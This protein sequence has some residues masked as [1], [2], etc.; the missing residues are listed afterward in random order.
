MEFM[1]FD[2]IGKENQLMQDSKDI[3][4]FIHAGRGKLTLVR[5]DNMHGHTYTFT[6]PRNSE[7]FEP[8]TIFV[9]VIHEGHSYYLGVLT[10][11]K[12]RLTRNSKFGP[13]T[14]AVKGANYIIRMSNNQSTIDKDLMRIYNSGQCCVCG[15]HLRSI[16]SLHK[17]IGRKCLNYWDSGILTDST[18]FSDLGSSDED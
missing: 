10:N 2:P 6:K 1:T 8:G 5:T 3:Y 14:E 18:V 15:R 12:L 17:G 11:T 16:T 9:N 4:R 7:D 13:H